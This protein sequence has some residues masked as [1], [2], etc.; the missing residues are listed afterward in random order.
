MATGSD[1]DPGALAMDAEDGLQRVKEVHAMQPHLAA[2]EDVDKTK[3]R[4]RDR[5]KR[6]V[7]SS[8]IVSSSQ[9]SKPMARDFGDTLTQ[10]RS[11]ASATMHGMASRGNESEPG[12]DGSSASEDPA[13]QARARLS[14]VADAKARLAAAAEPEDEPTQSAQL[15]AEQQEQ[16]DQQNTDPANTEPAMARVRDWIDETQS[17]H[18][19]SHSDRQSSRRRCVLSVQHAYMIQHH[20]L[21]LSAVA[22]DTVPVRAT[23]RAT[24]RDLEEGRGGAPDRATAGRAAAARGLRRRVPRMPSRSPCTVRGTRSRRS[25]L[26]SA[27]GSG[28]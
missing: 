22:C 15:A 27:I 6:G 2:A 3:Q 14:R 19:S 13:A 26:R 5:A 18:D 25:M 28:L 4:L 16:Q 21:E 7:A 10:F 12:S 17:N 23:V 1:E 24:S 20:C 11:D 9:S 8:G